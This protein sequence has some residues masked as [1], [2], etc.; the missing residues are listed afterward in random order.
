[1]TESGRPILQS[2][3]EKRNE[4]ALSSLG[5]GRGAPSVYPSRTRERYVLS[6]VRPGHEEPLRL[7]VGF[8][9]RSIDKEAQPTAMDVSQQDFLRESEAFERV[10]PSLLQTRAGR[11]VA[12]LNGQIIDED[13]EEFALAERMERDHRSEFVLIRRVSRDAIEDHFESPEV[14]MP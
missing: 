14:Q 11:F 3:L 5:A 12:V 7:T 9:V 1:M 4:D 2:E 13:E 8:P 10:L 6:I